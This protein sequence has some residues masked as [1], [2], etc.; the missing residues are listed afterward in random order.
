MTRAVPEGQEL[1][2][3][4]LGQFEAAQGAGGYVVDVREPEEY[5]NGHVPGAHL[6]PL[7]Q[8]PARLSDIPADQTVYVIC[9]HGVRS[10]TAAA[11]MAAAGRDVRSV[12]G[13][14][15]GWARRGLPLVRGSEPT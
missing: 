10:L 14:T 5:R 8:V 1:R 11:V 12:A 15:L 13:G 6:I 9:A 2:E 3:V 4:D 7:G